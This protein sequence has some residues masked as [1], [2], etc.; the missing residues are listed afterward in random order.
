[1]AET[2]DILERVSGAIVAATQEQFPDL[3][4]EAHR[5]DRK[6]PPVPACLIDLTEFVDGDDSG[7]G[8]LGVVAT[9]EAR[10]IIGFR[11]GAGKSA[12]M[13][14][15]KLAGAWAA[16]AR[17]QRWGC[18]VGP[19]Q[20]LGGFCD[21]FDPE[22]DKYEVWRV[23]WTQEIDLGGSVWDNDGIR[24]ERVFLGVTP[25]IGPDHIDDYV[26][27]AGPVEASA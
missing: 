14:V 2:I 17:L 26:Q 12:K 27:V 1:M 8:Q 23:E 9:F 3:Y 18:P 20:V 24:P 13:E 10:F 5:E 6:A 11:Q 4:V 16:F 21:D 19:A 15:R 25:E 22:L 7:T